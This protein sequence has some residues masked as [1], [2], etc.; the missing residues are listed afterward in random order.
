MSAA[1][2]DELRAAGFRFEAAGPALRIHHPPGAMT[3]ER[4]ALIAS[5]KPEIMAALAGAPVRCGTCQHFEPDPINP[6]A[7]LGRCLAGAAGDP[8]APNARL[9]WPNLARSCSTWRPGRAHLFD[10]ARAACEGL[11][12]DP[13]AL[14]AWLFEQGQPAWCQPAAVRRWAEIIN[15]RG[16]FP[17][18]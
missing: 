11:E 14:T 4:R 15:D 3:P 6:A 18:E 9:P 13:S 17:N 1:F 12:V 8:A 16:G 10:L 7:G 5:A 2:L